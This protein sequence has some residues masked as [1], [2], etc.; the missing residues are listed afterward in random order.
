[1]KEEFDLDCL[2]RELDA[3][4]RC[5]IKDARKQESPGV[6]V[7]CLDISPNAACASRMVTGPAPHRALKSSQRLAVS[8][9]HSSSGDAKEMRA[10][11]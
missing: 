10:C 6:R 9:F 11:F 4:L 1:M 2:V 8:T 3:T 7:H 5:A